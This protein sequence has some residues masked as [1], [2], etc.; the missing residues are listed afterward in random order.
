MT[1]I[2]ISQ[3]FCGTL[4]QW[5]HFSV[6]PI[7]G[8]HEGEGLVVMGGAH[9]GEGLVVMGGAHEGEGLVVMGGAH[10]RGRTGLSVVM[11]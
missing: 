5:E 6:L 3:Y 4:Y 8:A 1:T 9:E 11:G 2:F 10:E 7:H